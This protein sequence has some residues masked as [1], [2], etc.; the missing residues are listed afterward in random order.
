VTRDELAELMS[1]CDDLDMKLALLE[2]FEADEAQA[3]A[4]LA[5]REREFWTELGQVMVRLMTAGGYAVVGGVLLSLMP[6]EV[7]KA[8]WWDVA[9]HPAWNGQTAKLVRF[10]DQYIR[11]AL[12]EVGW[13]L[14][15]GL[16]VPDPEIPF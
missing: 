12:S 13:E 1:A 8:V 10:A 16:P 4:R 15:P 6:A 3:E 11:E 5:K 7:Q 14:P 9:R 2:Q